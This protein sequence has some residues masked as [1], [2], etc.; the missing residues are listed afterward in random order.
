M[1]TSIDLTH[2]S[3][4]AGKTIK[5]ISNDPTTSMPPCVVNANQVAHQL[6]VNGRGNMPTKPNR[7]I[8]TTVEQSEQLLVYPLTEEEYRK[9]IATLRNNKA[10][11][12]DDVQVEQHKHLE[13][14]AHR[15]LHSMLNTCFTENMIPKVWRQSRII[16][17]LKPGKDTPIPKSYRPISLLCHTYKL[18]ERLILNRITPTVESHLIK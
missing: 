4:K 13:P 3:R 8:L 11:G 14:R 1:I 15:W 12:I 2:N 10:A 9:G 17:I 6:L 18:Y 16:V 5:N 7:P